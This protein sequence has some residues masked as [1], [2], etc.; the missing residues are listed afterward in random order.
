MPGRFAQAVYRSPRIHCPAASSLPGAGSADAAGALGIGFARAERDRRRL[1]QPMLHA[2]CLR[3]G[4][5][6][7]ETALRRESLRC[8]VCPECGYWYPVHPPPMSG[9]VGAGMLPRRV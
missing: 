7:M 2:R 8:R 4:Y 1:R 6:L 5:R 3:C 9:R